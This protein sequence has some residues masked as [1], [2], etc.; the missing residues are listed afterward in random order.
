MWESDGDTWD[1]NKLQAGHPITTAVTI[2]GKHNSRRLTHE[3]HRFH[4]QN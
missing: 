3:H 2:L 1:S 4:V